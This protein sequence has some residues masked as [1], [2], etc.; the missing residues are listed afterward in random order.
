MSKVLTKNVLTL[1]SKLKIK[2]LIRRNNKWVV[3]KEPKQ[4]KIFLN[5]LR[6]NHKQET[7][8]RIFHQSRKK[9]G[10]FKIAEIFETT[11]NQEKEHAKR[12]FKIS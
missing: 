6:V 8:I 5:L 1:S 9:K 12:M 11:A 10:M 7:A 4:R 2:E 3:L